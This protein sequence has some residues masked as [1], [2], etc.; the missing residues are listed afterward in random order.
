MKK[1][2]VRWIAAGILLALLT[3][4]IFVFFTSPIA[5]QLF[6]LFYSYTAC[7][8]LGSALS[9]SRIKWISIE[10]L[11]SIVFFTLAFLGFVSSPLWVVLGFLLHGTWDLLHHPRVIKTKVVRWFP[12][13][14][15][16]FDFVVA[17]YLFI[18]FQ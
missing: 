3:I 5:Y 11:M 14:C 17:V 9:D 18:F 10:F 1:F 7:V 4:R 12:P 2:D 8:Y 16:V 13:L 6:V 15:A